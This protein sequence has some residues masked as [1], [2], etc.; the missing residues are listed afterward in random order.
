MAT[1]LINPLL[2][3]IALLVDD[4]RAF[5][6]QLYPTRHTAYRAAQEMVQRTGKTVH[7][8][9]FTEWL[10]ARAMDANQARVFLSTYSGVFVDGVLT[11]L[12][13]CLPQQVPDAPPGAQVQLMGAWFREGARCG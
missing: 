3:Y 8:C 1:R 9:Y 11:A 12:H 7:L 2:C 4:P 5:P 13:D 6:T 10:Q